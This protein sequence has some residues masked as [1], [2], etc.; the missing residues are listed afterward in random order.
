LAAGK[1]GKVDDSLAAYKSLL[2]ELIARRPSGTRQRIAEAF[3][4]HKSFVSQITNPNYR[5]PLPAQHVGT[6][7]KICHLSPEEMREFLAAYQDAHPSQALGARED[8]AEG[9]HI[10]RIEVP[11]FEDPKKQRDIEDTIKEMAAR[12]I[13]LAR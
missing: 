4:T 6:I 2:R 3:G 5:V 1:K 11:H 12:I 8:R 10:L 13:A 9:S 7:A